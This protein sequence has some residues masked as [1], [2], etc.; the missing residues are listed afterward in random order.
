MASSKLLP[1]AALSLAGALAI[2]P[3][4]AQN[5]QAGTLVATCPAASA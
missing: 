5:V 1:L 4:Q 3:A 2:N